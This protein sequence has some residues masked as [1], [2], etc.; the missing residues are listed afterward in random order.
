RAAGRDH[1]L[2]SAARP[3]WSETYVMNLLGSVTRSGRITRRRSTGSGRPVNGQAAS[4]STHGRERTRCG[5]AHIGSRRDRRCRAFVQ[6]AGAVGVSWVCPRCGRRFAHADQF[7]S[8]DT[9]DVDDHFTGRAAPL[10]E[11]FDRLIESLPSGVQ[12]KALQTVIVLSAPK[13]FSFVT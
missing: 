3:G 13:T 7:H 11:S 2:A 8:H 6:D 10:R 4:T 5:Q 1:S 9:V 12:V